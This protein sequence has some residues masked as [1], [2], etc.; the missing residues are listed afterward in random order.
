MNSAPRSSPT[1]P[2][3]LKH[4]GSQL[5]LGLGGPALPSWPSWE[6]LPEGC[7]AEALV[8]LA[9]LLARAGLEEESGA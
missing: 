9:R 5:V 1:D 3:P 6:S 2:L 4:I 8:V 7:R